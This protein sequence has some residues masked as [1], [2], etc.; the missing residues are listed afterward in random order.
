VGQG[1]KVRDARV[2]ADLLALLP[3]ASLLLGALAE[4]PEAAALPTA[5][6][7][8]GA[9]DTSATGNPLP[10][11]ATLPL[12][13]VPLPAA[14]PQALTPAPAPD[15]AVVASELPSGMSESAAL[16]GQASPAT[17][18]G[19]GTAPAVTVGLLGQ[20]AADPMA[21]PWTSFQT[22]L[23][24]AGDGAWPTSAAEVPRESASDDGLPAGV[25]LITGAGAGA[26]PTHT[27]RVQPAELPTPVGDPRWTPALAERVTWMVEGDVKHA[28]L[29][30]NPPDLG[31][32]EVHIAMVDEEARITFTAHHAAVRDAVEAALPRLREM[33]G[34]SGVSLVHVDVSGQGAGGQRAPAEPGGDRWAPGGPRA[35]VA[36]EEGFPVG[37]VG[38]ARV[39]LFDA[40]A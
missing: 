2:E 4:A 26:V 14:V 35:R 33:L 28:E 34:S 40:Y 1:Q 27:P 22:A 6:L 38:A 23:I 29:R 11:A 7:Q 32:L 24:Q 17:L 12:S 18:Q 10:T 36:A 15:P 16:L 30:L 31:P 8:A 20:A 3:F 39:G 21:A 13:V 19:R 37:A 5:D 25:A 9:D